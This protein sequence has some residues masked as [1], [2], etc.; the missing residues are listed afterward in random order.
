[1]SEPLTDEEREELRENPLTVHLY[2]AHRLVGLL[3]DAERDRVA[4]LEEA[5]THIRGL[6]TGER[7]DE[8]SR[9]D[10]INALVTIVDVADYALRAALVAQG[11]DRE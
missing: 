7:G 4:A 8:A 10:P 3:L 6:A 5:L 11:P 9:N 2:D 1:M